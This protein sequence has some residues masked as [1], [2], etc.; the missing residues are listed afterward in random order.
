MAWDDPDLQR[1][2]GNLMDEYREKNALD[3]QQELRRGQAQLAKGSVSGINVM[4][5]ALAYA[6]KGVYEPA[7]ETIDR[8]ERACQ[9]LSMTPSGVDLDQLQAQIEQQ[10]QTWQSHIDREVARLYQHHVGMPMPGHL[11]EQVAGN[12]IREVRR[13][14]ERR[15]LELRHVGVKAG[16]DPGRNLI[17]ELDGVNRYA[18]TR[19][20]FSLFQTSVYQ[21]TLDVIRPVDSR[22]E[23]AVKVQ[24]LALLLDQ[25]NGDVTR[26]LEEAG[27]QVPDGSINRVEALL[28]HRGIP[29]TVG[30]INVL[31]DVRRLGNDYPR[32]VG[33]REVAA[34][35]TRLG[36]VLPVEDPVTAW[37][38]ILRHT[39]ESLRLL[40]SSLGAST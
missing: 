40:G 10:V 22:D 5:V 39:I 11:A 28:D 12:A 30:T 27:R 13:R 32:H 6:S 25:I 19:L 17:M 34:A 29:V 31:R 3:T 1:Y 20:G 36:L 18:R 26:V 21:A 9:A 38:I 8:F 16:P 35:A 15:K 33:N 14:I 7:L 2:F 4:R 37:S 23:F 24:A